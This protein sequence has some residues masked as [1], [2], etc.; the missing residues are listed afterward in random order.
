ME[1]PTVR[2]IDSS[3]API[4]RAVLK[5]LERLIHDRAAGTAF[6]RMDASARREVAVIM[7]RSSLFED[8]RVTNTKTDSTE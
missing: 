1:E 8:L 7:A 5:R 6:E 4:S 2:S 3:S